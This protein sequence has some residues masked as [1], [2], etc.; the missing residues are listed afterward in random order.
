MYLVRWWH[1]PLP[2]VHHTLF[3]LL[4]GLAIFMMV[5]EPATLDGGRV[6]VELAHLVHRLVLVLVRTTVV[7]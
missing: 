2:V 5:L 1:G 6:V 3:G 7:A 4:L